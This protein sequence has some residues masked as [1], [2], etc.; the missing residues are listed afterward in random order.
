VVCSVW[1]IDRSVPGGGVCLR[2]IRSRSARLCWISRP[3]ATWRNFAASRMSRSATCLS[4]ARTSAAC[5]SSRSALAA[6]RSATGF[7]NGRRSVV[8]LHGFAASTFMR[9]LLR[10]NERD[11]AVNVH[12]QSVLV[13]DHR[14]FSSLQSSLVLVW[15]CAWWGTSLRSTRIADA[16]LRGNL[17]VSSLRER[18]HRGK[19]RLAFERNHSIS[20]N[21]VR[22]DGTVVSMSLSVT[23][24]RGL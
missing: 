6:S 7:A 19:V 8:T 16:D 13:V 18:R 9:V 21:S 14:P 5:R 10:R 17:P 23:T 12:R 24:E 20:H 22:G 4:V 2:R 15:S 3:R 11:G 1:F